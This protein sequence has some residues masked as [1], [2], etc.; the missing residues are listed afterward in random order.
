[1]L[2]VL[3]G[4]IGAV[5][6]VVALGRQEI[7]LALVGPAQQRA[8]ELHC[9]A[10]V[11]SRT[12]CRQTRSASS[13]STPRH[14]VVDLQPLARADAAHALVDVVGGHA[15]HIAGMQRAGRKARRRK[16]TGGFHPCCSSLQETRKV[17]HGFGIRR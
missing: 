3:G 13:A 7:G 8:F 11:V 4:G 15:Q 14:E 2:T 6:H 16:V 5:G 1:M 10:L 17:Q 9:I 12:S